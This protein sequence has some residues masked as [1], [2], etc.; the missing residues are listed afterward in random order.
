MN[1]LQQKTFHSNV[2]F[3]LLH[4]P[5]KIVEVTFMQHFISLNTSFIGDNAANAA[6]LCDYVNKIGLAIKLGG[7]GGRRRHRRSRPQRG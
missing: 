3:I 5:A 7:P 6:D 1:I 2:I 4:C